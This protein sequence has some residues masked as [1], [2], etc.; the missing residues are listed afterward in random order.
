MA[1]NLYDEDSIESLT[2]RE[3]VR[4]RPGVYA[5]DTSNPNHLLLE[6]FSNAL[7]EHNI[8]HGTQINVDIMENGTCRVE[9][10]A[11]G[12][13]INVM[14]DDGTTV[15]EAAFSVMNTSGKFS[16]DG[17]YEGSSLGLNGMGSKL[18][19]FLSERFNVISWQKGEYEHLWF[20]DGLFIKRECGKWTDTDC[21]SGTCVT[22]KP[23][24]QF[25]DTDKTDIKFFE[26]FF[27]DIAC[28]CPHL[29][30]V[31][32]N[33]QIKQDGIEQLIDRKLNNEI[34]VINNRLVIEHKDKNGNE[35]DLA[36]SFCGNSGSKII[37][38]VNYGLTTVGPH[39]TSMKSTITRVFNAWAKENGLLKAKDKNLDGSSIQEGML[40]VSNIVT[41]NVAYN[42]Q[43]KTTV[44]KMDS[45]F[46]TAELAK[47]LEL[48]MDTNPQDAKAIIEKALVSRKA[49]EAA[50]KAREAVKAKA[51]VAAKPKKKIDLPSKLADCYSKDRMKCELMIVEGDSAGGNLKDMRDNE[52][53]AILPVRGKVLN[54]ETATV[55]AI[56]KNAEIQD[57]LNAF[58]LTKIA[59]KKE[60]RYD[61]NNLRYGKIIL[62]SDADI[63]GA[64]I[65]NLLLTFIWKYAPQLV[66]DGFVYAAVPPLYRLKDA[67]STIYLKDDKELEDFKS[68]H[69][70]TKY[71]VSRL[72]GLGEMSPEE[73]EEA[74][75]DPENRIIK[76]ITVDDI[77]E[78]T[79]LFTKLMSKDSAAK[80][81]FIEEHEGDAEIYV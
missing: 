52:F 15:L 58:G 64:H 4:L 13:P 11:Q 44:T 5:G 22:Y 10:K 20:E 72:K 81:R 78:T 41:K 14:R 71:Q 32:N 48:W 25:F 37:S 59:G 2:P 8:G 3:H 12:F 69:D 7:D 19:N 1:D 38:Y 55:A 21:P 54:V 63:D 47:Q 27:N 17:I 62:M 73:T 45:S 33:K 39:I 79:K 28:L 65:K 36:M 6:I 80:K 53:Q 68:N 49:A 42:A 61:K 18:T 30:I 24:P 43:V 31:L 46:A 70:I 74:L 75:L 29:T 56:E 40:L 26:N 76:Q 16:E 9:D 51:N 50:K 57:M 66:S 77:D 67:K 35:F 23:D 34:E 60:A